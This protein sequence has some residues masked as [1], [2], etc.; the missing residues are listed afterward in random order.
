VESEI[1]AALL[2]QAAALWLRAA[3]ALCAS[4]EERRGEELWGEAGQG[5]LL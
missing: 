4:R 2:R 5:A 1:E 3:T